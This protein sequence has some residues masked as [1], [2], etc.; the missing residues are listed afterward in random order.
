MKIIPHGAAKEVTGSCHELH[1]ETESGIKRILLDCGLF[2]GHR[3]EAA[4]KN[5]EFA[6]DP[7]EMDA[8]ILSHAH[9]DHVGRVPLLSKKGF[10]A[11]IFCTYATKDLA[12]VMLQDSAYINEKDEEY[13]CKYLKKSMISCDGPLY[14]MEDALRCMEHFRG[15]NYY[16]WFDVCD[17]IRAQFL[18]AGHIVGAAMLVLEIIENGTVHRIGFS[19]DLGRNMLP[20]IRDPADMP[21]VETLICESTYGNRKHEDVVSAKGS[22]KDVIIRTAKRGGKVLIPAFSLERTQEIVYDLHVLWDSKEIPAIPIVIDSPLAT[23]VTDVFMK[24][25]ECY[26]KSMYENFLSRAHNPFQFSLVRYTES[27]EESKELNGTPGPMVIMAGSGMCEAGRI[28]HHLK[29]EIEDDR[30]TILAVGYMAEHTLGR[31]IIDPEVT[32]VKIFDKMYK[33]KAETVYIN[34]YSGH[35]DMADLDHYVCSI[36]GLKT[37]ILVH[38]EETQMQPFADRMKQ[39]CSGIHIL[40]PERDEEIIL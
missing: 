37:L 25:P 12:E 21:P 24:H 10:N 36:K 35:A 30:N 14:T 19:G 26:D 34:A 8:M 27:V 2:Q 40:M 17:G 7:Q 39:A 32:E 16:E 4:V 33:K 6:F 1:I 3:Q 29:N 20:I 23:K 22:L 15:Q 9:A 28:R 13:F 5:A 18:D 38:G 31:S 11:P